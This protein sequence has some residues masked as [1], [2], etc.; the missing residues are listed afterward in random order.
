MEGREPLFSSLWGCNTSSPYGTSLS[1]RRR[2][3]QIEREREGR[4]GR[5]GR[6]RRGEKTRTFTMSST[7]HFIHIHLNPCVEREESEE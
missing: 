3:L 4:E 7:Q 1:D 6:D 2:L 5:R